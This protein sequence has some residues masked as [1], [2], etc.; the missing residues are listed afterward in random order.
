MVPTAR[1]AVQSLSTSAYCRGGIRIL[2]IVVVVR[3]ARKH[4]TPQVGTVPGP[5]LQ[6][7]RQYSPIP[8][9]R[10]LQRTYP[11]SIIPRAISSMPLELVRTGG[12]EYCMTTALTC[13][14]CSGIHSSL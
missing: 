7:D 10:A 12:N 3:M 6:P 2:C 4:V 14:F 11:T 9:L 8:V 5:F 13:G 1:V